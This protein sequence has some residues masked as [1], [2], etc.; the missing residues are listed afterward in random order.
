MRRDRIDGRNSLVFGKL[1]AVRN[2]EVGHI[3]YESLGHAQLEANSEEL[4]PII[5]IDCTIAIFMEHGNV[6]LNSEV[7]RIRCFRAYELL[8]IASINA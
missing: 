4:D 3:L 2:F 8:D 6:V 1:K 7:I 5:L